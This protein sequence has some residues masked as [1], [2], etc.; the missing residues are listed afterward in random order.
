V[1]AGAAVLVVVSGV[2]A[3][4]V[5]TGRGTPIRQKSVASI[6]FDVNS[7]DCGSE[8]IITG[9]ARLKAPAEFCIADISTR[10]VGVSAAALDLTCQYLITTSG[11]RLPPDGQGTF[12]LNGSQAPKGK[13]EVR[14]EPQ[15]VMLAFDAPH[16]TEPKA[17]ELHAS[18][19][20]PG[21][22]IRGSR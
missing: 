4:I 9:E 2:I 13:L 20:S 1:I 7:V 10:S 11:T 15:S 14:N 5:L 3:G 17:L 19:N 21:V 16:G 12:I 18:C 6:H 8:N 22:T